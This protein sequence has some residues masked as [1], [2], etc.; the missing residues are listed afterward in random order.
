MFK[1][2]NFHLIM[3]DFANILMIFILL[4]PVNL[5]KKFI[6]E[7]SSIKR[8]SLYFRLARL[9]VTCYVATG[10]IYGNFKISEKNSVYKN[11]FPVYKNW[12]KPKKILNPK[13]K[14]IKSKK[15]PVIL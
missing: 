4:F 9:V 5:D 10:L 14:I 7:C 12:K 13:K 2:K 3:L 8:F 1:S 11:K 6:S 15:K